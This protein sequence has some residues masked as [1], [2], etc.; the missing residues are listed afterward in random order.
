[1]Y[2]PAPKADASLGLS[3]ADFPPVIT[4]VWPDNWLAVEVFSAMG[5]QWRTGAAG[6]TGLDYGP[7]PF[8]MRVCDVTASRRADTFEAVR[9]MEAAALGK[10]GEM[11]DH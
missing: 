9:V 8:V 11:R 10:M 4:E 3:A 2:T 7:L 6:A 5:T 1:M